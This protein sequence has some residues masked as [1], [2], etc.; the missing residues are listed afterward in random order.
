MGRPSDSLQ[1]LQES[2]QFGPENVG[3]ANGESYQALE[4]QA[5]RIEI[6][7]SRSW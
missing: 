6:N 3:K 2:D 5:A 7:V 4:D 1:P